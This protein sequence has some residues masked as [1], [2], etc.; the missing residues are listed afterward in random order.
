MLLRPEVHTKKTL[1]LVVALVEIRS[2][3]NDLAEEKEE[4]KNRHNFSIPFLLNTFKKVN[5]RI[6][7]THQTPL[8]CQVC[9]HVFAKSSYFTFNIDIY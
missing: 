5:K 2:Q 7:Q 3:I 4:E 1:V 6:I 8:K 9:G